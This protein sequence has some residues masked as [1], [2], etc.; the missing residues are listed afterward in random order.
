MS[1]QVAHRHAS[2]TG[3]MMIVLAKVSLLGSANYIF[4]CWDRLHCA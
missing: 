3:Q 1:K 4:P 2:D